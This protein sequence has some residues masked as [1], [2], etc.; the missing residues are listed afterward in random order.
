MS[1]TTIDIVCRA[2][3]AIVAALR[4]EYGLPEYHNIVIRMTEETEN[5]T[6]SGVAGYEEMKT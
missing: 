1:K 2:L 4:K 5:I 6:F 3:L